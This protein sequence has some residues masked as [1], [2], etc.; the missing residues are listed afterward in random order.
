M[1]RASNS[2]LVSDV[3]TTPIKLKYSS[4][5]SNTAICDSGIYAQSG[6]N[7]PVTVTGSVPQRTLR[8]LSIRHL[9]YSNFL[10][11]SYQISGSSADNFL[12]STAAS[13]TFENNTTLSSS[14]DIRYFPTESLSKIKIINI[15]KNTFGEKISRKSFFLTGSNYYL[16][17]DG[18]GNLI[19]KYN[20]NKRVGNIIYPQGFAIITNSDYYCVIDGGP[21]TFPKTYT[22]D[23]T[24]NPKTFN[25]ILDAQADCAPIDTTTLTLITA[26]GFLFPSS[27]QNSAGLITLSETDTLTN[28]VGIYRDFY[29]VKSTYCASSDK[30][31]ITVNIVDCTVTGLTTATL[32]CGING[33][34]L[35]SISAPTPTP[36]VTPGCTPTST[37]IPPS[38]SPT[39]N[40][41]P[42]PSPT[43]TPGPTPTATIPPATPGPT[44]TATIP[45]PTPTPSPTVTPIQSYQY[46][47]AE[48][49]SGGSAGIVRCNVDQV[50]N[51]VFDL[52]SYVCIRL[53]GFASGPAYNIDLGDGESYIGNNCSLCPTPPP[54]PT[55]AQIPSYPYLY[56]TSDASNVGVCCQGSYLYVDE[57]GNFVTTPTAGYTLVEYFYVDDNGAFP[58]YFDNATEMYADVLLLFPVPAGYYGSQAAGYRQIAGTAGQFSTSITSCAGVFCP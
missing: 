42:T 54:P 9:F 11:S 2:L 41:T 30:Q 37:P 18:N 7:G 34:S 31:P 22:F 40:P 17:D 4:S 28:R 46:Y 20:G 50:L 26:S 6:L 21:F 29:T 52:G 51:S 19:D 8:Y 33:L 5:Y 53:T 3:T 32:S 27:S 13:G 12:Q 14:A 43:T 10:T 44:P 38:P 39:P 35:T 58:D 48:Y 57:S 47:T 36:T 15:P 56:N 16:A 23:I 49:C 45:P 25:P 1:S 24:D 55:Y